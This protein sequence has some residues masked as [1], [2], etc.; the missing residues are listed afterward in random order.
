MKHR[1]SLG[2]AC[3]VA[4]ALAALLDARAET[5]QRRIPATFLM[6]PHGKVHVRT[7]SAAIERS[8]SAMPQI[9][10]TPIRHLLEPVSPLL[11]RLAQANQLITEGQDLLN[12]L[13]VQKAVDAFQRAAKLQRSVFHLMA[14]S[15]SGVEEHGRV[16]VELAIAQ[17]LAGNEAEAKVAL[18]QAI[19]LVPKLE[20]DPQKFPPQ[21]KR[22]FDEV[23][24]LVDEMGIGDAQINTDPPGAEV[25]VN[26]NFIG[27]S[28]V[29]ARGLVAGPN[30][31]TVARLGYR[32]RTGR[33]RV[34][35]G[36]K[37]STFTV[38]LHPLARSP[39][40]LM[41]N[42][43]VEA[44]TRRPG[45]AL[46]ALS[47]KL[48]RQ[49]LFIASSASRDDLVTV[50]LHAYDAK[51]NRA[52]GAAV[53][54]VTALDPERDCKTLVESLVPFVTW[55]SPPPTTRRRGGFWERVRSWPYLW[56]VVGAVV[57]AAVVGTSVGLGVYYGTREDNRARN[58]LILPAGVY[59]R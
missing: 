43:E 36:G 5:R 16:Y 32:T 23:R 12:N 15:Q 3:A 1:N 14:V 29:L 59:C 34:E 58:V 13:E 4:L 21:S 42:A 44:Q 39:L 57:G 49:M 17:F 24:F 2:L 56:P 7:V 55:R 41:A 35:G 51:G 19:V 50:T 20:F 48:G 6:D 28:P 9:N 30:L 25:Q 46:A 8:L 27:F 40:A 37:V 38:R 52:S 45:P 26:G 47:R 11:D 10:F 53:G 31:V 18:Q 54:T 22:M 33:A